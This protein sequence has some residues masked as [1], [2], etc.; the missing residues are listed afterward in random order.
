M[1]SLT[2]MSGHSKA[3]PEAYM[4]DWTL[5]QYFDKN[6]T[7]HVFTTKNYLIRCIKI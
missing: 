3:S 2:C 5:G 4:S 1:Y 6:D 7:G